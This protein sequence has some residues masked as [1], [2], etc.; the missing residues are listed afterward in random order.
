MMTMKWSF[1]KGMGTLSD[2]GC[3]G[4]EGELYFHPQKK[5]KLVAPAGYVGK[6]KLIP[7]FLFNN[8]LFPQG[9]ELLNVFEMRQRHLL[10]SVGMSSFGLCYT[11]QSPMKIGLVGTMA[12]VQSKKILEDGRTLALIE[13]GERFFVEEIVGE[14]PFIKARVRLFRDFCDNPAAL[15]ALER[16]VFA[17]VKFNNKLVQMLHPQR[18]YAISATVMKYRPPVFRDGVREIKL[19]DAAA[20]M[21]RQSKFSFA[22]MDMLH[23]SPGAKLALLQEHNLERKFV[24]FLTI[25]EQGAEYLRKELLGAGIAT[26]QELQRIRQRVTEDDM[27][28][29]SSP[30]ASSSRSLDDAVMTSQWGPR[31]ALFE[32]M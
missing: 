7:I 29:A 30:F 32:D 28:I 1:S 9:N 8:V 4:S 22:V 20:E 23:S 19:Y 16:K 12:K 27:E 26:E 2:L 11:T 18:D 25:L 21:E 17:E 15:A 3:I 13:G 6:S 24:R 14:K 31:P 5:A 10:D